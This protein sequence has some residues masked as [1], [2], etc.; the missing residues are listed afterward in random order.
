MKEKDNFL[1]YHNM[2]PMFEE[3]TDEEAGQVLKAVFHYSMHNELADFPKGSG[4]SILL[5]AIK[6]SIDINNQKY[7]ERCANNRERALK[8]WKKIFYNNDSFTKES[9]KTYCNENNIDEDFDNILIK[10]KNYVDSGE[11]EK[12]KE[13]FSCSLVSNE[14][15]LKA[16]T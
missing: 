8:R 14:T 6:T 7:E 16:F 4:Q 2:F 12:L 5:K 13:D 3:L 9:F 1:L 15:I 11:I 10:Q